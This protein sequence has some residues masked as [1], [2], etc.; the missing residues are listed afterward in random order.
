[1]GSRPLRRSAPPRRPARAAATDSS[2]LHGVL[3]APASY[4]EQ[5]RGSLQRWEFSTYGDFT[6][7]RVACGWGG[8]YCPTGPLIM[9]FSTPVRGSQ[10]LRSVSLRPAAEF[11]V[12]DTADART[13]WALET[14][15]KART[16]YVV[17]ADTMLRDAFGQRLAGN[18]GRDGEDH[19]LSPAINYP[20]GRS[21]VERQRR[22]HAS[23]SAS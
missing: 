21:V 17:L 19:R 9:T 12:S 20:S 13:S 6:I 10:V 3:V 8:P 15:L 16:G 5:G 7:E 14:Q 11:R 4:D 1:M 2:R 22:A 23:G 18:P